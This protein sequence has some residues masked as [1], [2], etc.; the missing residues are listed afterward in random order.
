[1]F[2]FQLSW[3]RET[4]KSVWWSYVRTVRGM[5][6]HQ[7][8]APGQKIGNNEGCVAGLCGAF[9]D[10]Q[11]LSHVFQMWTSVRLWAICWMLNRW[12][13][14]KTLHTNVHVFINSDCFYA[15]RMGCIGKL[16]LAF[17]NYP[18]PS[19]RL[20]P[21]NAIILEGLLKHLEFFG[22]ILSKHHTKL[23]G[24]WLFKGFLN[25]AMLQNTKTHFMQRYIFLLT[26]AQSKLT[27]SCMESADP[28]PHFQTGFAMLP[29]TVDSQYNHVYYFYNEPCMTFYKIFLH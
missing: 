22:W 27:T 18:V 25:C 10:P 28:P 17:L 14:C 3:V 20:W 13:K 11:S 29:S 23:Y 26:P 21:W 12:S 8:V 24:V 1:M 7:G 5:E 15:S 16:I 19:P 2:S 4:K 9:A 6:G